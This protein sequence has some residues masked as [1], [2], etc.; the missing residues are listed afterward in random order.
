MAQSLSRPGITKLI[1]TTLKD[2]A[3]QYITAARLR[4]VV[5][6]IVDSTYGMKT[7]WAGTI[8]WQATNDGANSNVDYVVV[9]ESYADTNFM[10]DN[11]VPSIGGGYSPR[12]SIL[13]GG[14]NIVASNGTGTGTLLDVATTTTPQSPIANGSLG[15]G[16]RFNLTITN[17]ICT[18]IQVANPGTG[19]SS[20]YLKASGPIGDYIFPTVTFTS[21]G[22]VPTIQFSTF[23]F[24][25]PGSANRVVYNSDGTVEFEWYVMIDTLNN[26]LPIN[27]NS[28]S[29]SSVVQINYK[30]RTG[31]NVPKIRIAIPSIPGTATYSS[32][33]GLVPGTPSTYNHYH[34]TSNTTT[35][36]TYDIIQP[37]W[38]SGAK[39]TQ[40][41]LWVAAGSGPPEYGTGF[42][43]TQ[44]N[45]LTNIGSPAVTN[46][47]ADIEIRIPIIN[48]TPV[49]I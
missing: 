17:G 25:Y 1:D 38:I 36:V 35:A 42:G 29:D 49:I 22:R 43:F 15:K 18:G 31:P 5:N 40:S 9:T 27:R 8:D 47:K 41:N 30:D 14:L 12:Y 26:D 37:S 28:F 3:Q 32:P 19:Y 16:A 24:V 46:C 20:T 4:S 2:N 6:P 44:Y 7:I 13:D 39:S 48:S 21:G 45:K 10:P 33:G 11:N 34:L 23:C